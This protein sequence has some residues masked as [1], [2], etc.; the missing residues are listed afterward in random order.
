MQ[1]KL[2]QNQQVLCFSLWVS[3]KAGDRGL[4]PAVKQDFER[5]E[6]MKPRFKRK[7]RG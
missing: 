7:Q 1:W 5:N 4:S 6:R 2:I 3:L